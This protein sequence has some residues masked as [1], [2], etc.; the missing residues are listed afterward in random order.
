MRREFTIDF[1][2]EL[3]KKYGQDL[4][5]VR[6][7]QKLLLSKKGK[8]RFEKYF[9]FRGT[10]YLLR[11]IG[12]TNSLFMNIN[13]QLDDIESEI[14]YLLIRELKPKKI[15]EIS[16]CGGWSTSWIL[17]AIKDNGT[18]R[19]YSYDI[20]DDST[21]VIPKQLAQ[22]RWAFFKGD[23][24]KKMEK[25]PKDMDYV[26][27]DAEHT[28]NFAEWYTKNLFPI[29]PKESTI[30]VHDVFHTTDPN[31]KYT[32]GGVVINWLTKNKTKYFTA[33]RAKNKKSFEKI[34][35]VRG[36]FNF[37]KNI[38]RSEAN[39]MIFFKK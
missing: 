3:Y 27:I 16:P 30:S 39:S 10:R 34:K 38:I 37:G 12:L 36:K 22:G 13:P 26:F 32:E 4:E 23:I 28:A 6:N 17:N 5:K 11:K 19:L 7:Y 21:K 24:K 8:T 14:T 9:L 31:G 25:I 15:V 1:V 2:L 33:S 18:G 29:I 20:V 35:L